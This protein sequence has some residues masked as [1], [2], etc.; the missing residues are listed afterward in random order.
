[1]VSRKLGKT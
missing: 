1:V